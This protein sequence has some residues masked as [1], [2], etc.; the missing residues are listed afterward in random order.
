MKSNIHWAN[1]VLLLVNHESEHTNVVY[2]IYWFKLSHCLIK[3]RNMEAYKGEKAHLH[4]FL[5]SIVA[6]ECLPSRT[7]HFTSGKNVSDTHWLGPSSVWAL[8]RIE[9]TFKLC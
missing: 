4:A 6:G 9:Q 1:R 2:Y 5:T 7:G 3:Q 8:W